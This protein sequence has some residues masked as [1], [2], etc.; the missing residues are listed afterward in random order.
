[1]A[2]LPTAE[3]PVINLAASIQLHYKIDKQK[4]RVM[5]MRERERER[6]RVLKASKY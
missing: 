4:R 3:A 2:K 6:E 5:G 1:M